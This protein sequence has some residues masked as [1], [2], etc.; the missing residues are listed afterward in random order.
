M[1]PRRPEVRLESLEEGAAAAEGHVVV[2]DVFRA[3]TT[4]AVALARGASR[5]AMVGDT[6][7]AL[8]LRRSGAVDVC[9]GERHGAR[10]AGFDFGNSPAALAKADLAG[11]AL[12]LT[13]SNG[14]RG[15]M[16]ARGARRLFAGALVNA[17][18]TIAAIEADRPRL[19]T[20]VAMGARSG[21]A[22][23][24]EICALYLRSR[25]QGHRPD[26]RAVAKL[27]ASLVAPIPDALVASG[28]YPPE[29]RK[30]ALDIDAV[31]MAMPVIMKGG[32]LVTSRIDV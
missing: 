26:R 19:V 12:A 9:V 3:F 23:E 29:D 31:P 16:A 11:R 4:A 22:A 5:I 1:A 28:D 14:T 27:I 2:I 8:R 7:E 25:L 17:G 15:L 6:K 20:L 21:R 18:A 13:T 10:P 24:D 30:V 32:V